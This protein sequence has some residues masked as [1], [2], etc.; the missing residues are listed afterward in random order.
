MPR[1]SV[2]TKLA[3]IVFAVISAAAVGA[4][5]ERPT[6]RPIPTMSLGDPDYLVFLAPP[7]ALAEEFAPHGPASKRHVGFGITLYT[8]STPIEL[9]KSELVAALDKAEATRYPVLI[10]LDDWNYMFRSTDPEILEWTAFPED[11][12]EFGPVATSRWIY[13]DEWTEIAPPPNYESPAF[14]AEVV[15]RLGTLGPIIAERLAEW[16]KRG[17]THLLAGVVCGWKSGIYTLTEGALSRPAGSVAP[18]ETDTVRTGYAALSA[19]G[20]DPESIGEA[21]RKYDRSE[22]EII[23]EI[24]A[25]IVRDYTALFTRTLAETGIPRERIYTNFTPWHS[26][27]AEDIPHRL[28]GDGQV[29]PLWASTNSFSRPGM[30]LANGSYHLDTLAS[31]LATLGHEQWAATG[32]E[33]PADATS[34]GAALAHLTGIYDKGAKLACLGDA[35]S[36]SATLVSLSDPHTVDAVQQWLAE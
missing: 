25:G 36:P 4:L 8:L 33:L 22:Q 18:D 24:L 29:Q 2:R 12:S 13:T 23:D 21:A 26:L 15:R 28:H 34:S 5:V 1:F 17:D 27:P 7:D 10:Q 31:D 9:M 11:G 6:D 35:V 32:V 14:R 30:V 19:R 3:I 16:R 20:H